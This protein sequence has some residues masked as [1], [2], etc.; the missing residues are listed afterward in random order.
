MASKVSEEEGKKFAEI[1][2][3]KMHKKLEL[4]VSLD[5]DLLGGFIM[6]VNNY[7]LDASASGQLSKI[8]RQLLETV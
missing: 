2:E 3:L 7:Q 5:R 4:K 6:E 1:L 8:S